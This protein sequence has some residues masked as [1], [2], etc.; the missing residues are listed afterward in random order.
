MVPNTSPA[1]KIC[2]V[3]GC[4]KLSSALKMCKMHY[5]RQM[6]HGSPHTVRTFDHDEMFNSRVEKTESCWMWTGT[7]N[8]HGYGGMT[9]NGKSKLVHRLSYERAKGQIPVGLQI[10]HICHNRICVN[11]DHLRPVNH[12]QN[13]E[14][15]SKARVDN[16]SGVRGV[17]WVP[18]RKRYRATVG[19][20]GK[21]I[22]IGYFKTLEEASDVVRNKRNELFT[23]N[24]L[25][26]I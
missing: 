23:H 9:I 12:K 21:R 15:L 16:K 8:A 19:H 20:N 3:E 13:Q 25:D 4:E 10:D 7:I 26:R 6:R 1:K 14:N 11:P 5:T 17:S 18:S 24:Q 22:Q 2:S